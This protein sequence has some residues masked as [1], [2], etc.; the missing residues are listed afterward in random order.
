MTTE[1]WTTQEEH[2]REQVEQHFANYVNGPKPESKFHV[3]QFQHGFRNDLGEMSETALYAHLHVRLGFDM[4]RANDF[5][6][7]IEKNASVTLYSE[8][9]QIRLEVQRIGATAARNC[10]AAGLFHFPLFSN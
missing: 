5:M 9:G 8:D 4:N 2:T 10:L 7:E 6:S 3:M 1:T